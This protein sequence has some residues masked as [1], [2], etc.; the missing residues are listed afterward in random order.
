GQ[1]L[2]DRRKKRRR[3]YILQAFTNIIYIK[4]PIFDP[5]RLLTRMLPYFRW[6]FT[7]WFFIVSVLFMTSALWLVLTHF[8][9]FRDR[10]PSYHEFFSSKTTIYPWLALA[11]VNA[12]QQFGHGPSC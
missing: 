6:I 2:F 12:L 4:I 1:P 3:T 5:E 10:L 11:R 9:T 8:E 7:T